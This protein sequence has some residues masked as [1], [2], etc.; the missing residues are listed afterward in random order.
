MN[1]PRVSMDCFIPVEMTLSQ[2]VLNINGLALPHTFLS[3]G[4]NLNLVTSLMA[5]E[6]RFLLPF[7]S[8]GED[9]LSARLPVCLS[10]HPHVPSTQLTSYL[11][12]SLTIWYV[13]PFYTTFPFF[14]S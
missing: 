12:S 6:A 1:R 7:C 2:A 4:I 3:W 5:Q 14:G 10:V 9:K 8:L 11:S 13:T